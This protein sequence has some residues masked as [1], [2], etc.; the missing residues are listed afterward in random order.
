MDE[1]YNHNYNY[2]PETKQQSMDLRH[3]GSS[4]PKNSDYNNPLE[5]FS[6]KFFWDQAGILLID[7]LPK[8]RTI[9]AEYYPSLLVQLKIIL[10]EK[11]RGKLTTVVLI[12]HDNALSHRAL[13]TQKKL[14][15]LG[16]QRLHHKPYF[17]DLARRTTTCSLDCKRTVRSPFFVRRVSPR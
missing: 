11:R 3:S 10:K 6:T 2:Y 9:N 17:P 1:T 4:H 14:A 8:G 16:F 12:L 13:A 5:N 15:Y 7:Y